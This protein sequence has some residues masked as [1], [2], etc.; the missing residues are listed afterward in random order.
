MKKRAILL[1]CA[2]GL[3]LTTCAC[4]YCSMPF[5]REQSAT[6]QAPTSDA[7]AIELSDEEA[8]ATLEEMVD[9]FFASRPVR[10]VPKD[11]D[12]SAYLVGSFAK[13]NRDF[14]KIATSYEKVLKSDKEN[15]EI[16]DNLFLYFTLAGK[17]DKAL[18]YAE[19]VLAQK[20]DNT[21]ARM[22]VLTEQIKAKKYDDALQNL[23]LVKNNFTGFLRP[24]LTSWVYVGL[25]KE[26]EALQS[27]ES[28]SQTD[29]FKAAYLLHRALILDYFGRTSKAAEAYEAL[30]KN[31]GA[32]NVRVFLQ[33]RNF[34]ERTNAIKDKQ[35]LVDAYRRLEE[36]SF[37]SKE[38]M[39]KTEHIE[40]ITSSAQGISWVFFD[41]SS[42]FAQMA[43]SDVALFFA[44]LANELNP[45]SS[46]T[47]L[48]LGEI[49]EMLDLPERANAV[50][51]TVKPEQNIYLSVQMRLIL[52][53]VKMGQMDKAV[54]L[55]QK[56][57]ADH[58][59]VALFYMTLGDI[60]R[61]QNDCTNALSAYQK[62]IEL[63]SA[64]KSQLAPVYFSIG[65]CYADLTQYDAAQEALEKAIDLN[66]N[67]PLYYNYLGYLW[68]EQ[69]KNVPEALALIQKAVAARPNEGSFLDSLGFAYYLQGEYEKALPIMEKATNLVAG[70]AVVNS[71][72]G[73]L[74]WRLG[75]FREARFQWTHAASLKEDSSEKLLAELQTKIHQGL[76]ELN[77]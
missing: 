74:Y 49:L 64:N 73:D 57:I 19:Q 24:L 18:P 25:N 45:N 38:M 72:L 62:T 37:I 63:V 30:M 31:Q 11:A 51:A 65:A 53:W 54:E 27:L 13:T 29:D 14:L 22:I 55:L 70:S 35:Y 23:S 46:V 39:T 17:V 15:K 4:V 34:E 61:S 36:E 59:A 9:A 52:N 5:N 6:K 10:D 67:N 16:Q 33:L 12:V 7:E 1:W 41:T 50:Y 28:L 75:R 42:A 58:P 44:E 20:P 48:Y 8:A 47:E 43:N 3:V 26:K 66:P 56:L 21:M 60:Y 40:R 76:P 71:H 2:L 32:Q 69:N 68:L 77:H